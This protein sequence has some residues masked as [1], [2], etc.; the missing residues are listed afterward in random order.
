MDPERFIFCVRTAQMDSSRHA[1]F[2]FGLICFKLCYI[3]QKGLVRAEIEARKYVLSQQREST[4]KE[5]QT[6]FAS[7]KL[8]S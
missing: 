8:K 5:R 4:S 3:V 6:E 2:C 1:L 7:P